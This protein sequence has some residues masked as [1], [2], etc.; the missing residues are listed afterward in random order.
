[1]QIN[2]EVSISGT[3]TKCHGTKCHGQN[4]M[5]KMS[6]TKWHEDKMSRIK[7]HWDKMSRDK[8]ALRQNV[9][10]GNKF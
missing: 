10:G 5:D 8:M 1:M 9:T 6:R 7:W 2:Y 4:V 3:R